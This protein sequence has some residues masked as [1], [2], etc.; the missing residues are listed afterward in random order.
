MG[1]VYL[2]ILHCHF[3][4]LLMITGSVM[5][6]W[7][8]FPKFWWW[9]AFC[10]CL[11]L[12]ILS[13]QKMDNR[14]CSISEFLVTFEYHYSFSPLP[15]QEKKRLDKLAVLFTKQSDYVYCGEAEIDVP[16]ACHTLYSDSIWNVNYSK[17]SACKSSIAKLSQSFE[18]R[19]DALRSRYGI[20][21][22]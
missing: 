4:N 18:K 2:D 14:W 6:N 20:S 17:L 13:R 15:H 3:Y 9:L 8:Y 5:A 19:I 21:S 10:A 11:V 12:L 1:Q 22:A 7:S 16:W